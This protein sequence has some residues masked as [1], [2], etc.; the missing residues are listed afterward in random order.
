MQNYTK[1][2][3]EKHAIDC[4][5]ARRCDVVGQTCSEEGAALCT[6]TVDVHSH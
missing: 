6:A 5:N 4:S 2:R 3:L 1:R